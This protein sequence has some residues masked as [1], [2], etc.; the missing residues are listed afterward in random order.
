MRACSAGSGAGTAA[1]PAPAADVAPAAPA[2]APPPAPTPAPPPAP[3][4]PGATATVLSPTL[5]MSSATTASPAPPPLLAH[6][7]GGRTG[8]PLP[9]HLMGARSAAAARPSSRAPCLTQWPVSGTARARCAGCAFCKRPVRQRMRAVQFGWRPRLPWACYR[10]P[11]NLLLIAKPGRRTWRRACC[12][13]CRGPAGAPGGA[14]PGPPPPS[15]L[16]PHLANLAHPAVRRR[17]WAPASPLCLPLPACGRQPADSVSPCRAHAHHPVHLTSSLE[18]LVVT[19]ALA[20][21]PLCAVSPS[22]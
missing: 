6:G 3:A 9:P 14:L 10:W 15:A 7:S 17:C 18:T 8:L 11:H 1:G 5:S 22:S 19:L 16:P 12:G 13:A 21:L 20:T 2:P 4:P